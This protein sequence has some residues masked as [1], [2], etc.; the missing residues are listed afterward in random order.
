M[1]KKKGK[2]KTGKKAGGSKMRQQGKS[3]LKRA[4]APIPGEKKHSGKAMV[5]KAF[6]PL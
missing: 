6:A 2:A 3:I 5:K 4:F 1:A